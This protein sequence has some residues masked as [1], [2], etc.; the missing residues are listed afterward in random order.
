[1]RC[2][3]TAVRIR[4]KIRCHA[5]RTQTA[6]VG[7]RTEGCRCAAYG[8][9]DQSEECYTAKRVSHR[10][11]YRLGALCSALDSHDTDHV[12]RLSLYFHYE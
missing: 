3:Q 5:E 2:L 10:E 7:V 6:E 4:R 9:S 1:M 11:P 8:D 12:L